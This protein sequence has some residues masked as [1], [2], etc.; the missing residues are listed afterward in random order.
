[1][2]NSTTPASYGARFFDALQLATGS[3]S[4]LAYA[5]IQRLRDMDRDQVLAVMSKVYDLDSLLRF[6]WSSPEEFARAIAREGVARARKPATDV[7]LWSTLLDL[8]P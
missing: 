6:D 2:T 8:L 1:M 7:V 4:G 3:T 5:D